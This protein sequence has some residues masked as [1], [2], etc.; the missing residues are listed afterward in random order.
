MSLAAIGTGKNNPKMRPYQSGTHCPSL[1]P[2]VTYQSR[3]CAIDP[4]T[5]AD[6]RA[7]IDRTNTRA[8]PPKDKLYLSIRAPTTE[9][10]IDHISKLA[11]S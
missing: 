9:V 6:G 4:R 1:C 11:T 5:R 8:P 3:P 10:S 2:R 7:R